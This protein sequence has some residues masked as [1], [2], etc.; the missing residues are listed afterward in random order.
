MFFVV[1]GME[2]KL[3]VNV[4]ILAEAADTEHQ[5][6]FGTRRSTLSNVSEQ[7]REIITQQITDTAN[8]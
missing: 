3:I 7:P 1:F 8:C 2:I 4:S 5:R 6:M